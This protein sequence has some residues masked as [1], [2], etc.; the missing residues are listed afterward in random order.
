MVDAICLMLRDHCYKYSFFV[1]LLF[2]KIGVE[3]DEGLE[4]TTCPINGGFQF[5]EMA[6]GADGGANPKNKIWSKWGW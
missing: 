4:F 6:V 1:F 2:A 3:V 5:I